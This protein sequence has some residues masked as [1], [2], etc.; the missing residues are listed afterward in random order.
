MKKEE[1][2]SI[3]G[4]SPAGYLWF[5]PVDCIPVT[6]AACSHTSSDLVVTSPLKLLACHYCVS[7]E[8]VWAVPLLVEVQ[9]SLSKSEGRVQVLS[10]AGFRG[11]GQ[12]PSVLFIYLFY[13]IFIF[14]ILYLFSQQQLNPVIGSAPF[15]QRM[16]SIGPVCFYWTLLSVVQSSFT[17]HKFNSIHK[18]TGG[19][20]EG[21]FFPSIKLVHFK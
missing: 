15:V 3:P 5:S 14:Y 10:V 4:I 8:E 18:Q 1:D 17:T 6:T 11:R 21:S 2:W 13:F 19:A 16:M 20:N 12:K 7:Q 9:T